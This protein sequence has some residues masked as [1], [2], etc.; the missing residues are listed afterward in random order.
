MPVYS[1]VLTAVICPYYKLNH[2]AN[3]FLCM[4]HSFPYFHIPT[5]DN[6]VP[7]FRIPSWNPTHLRLSSCSTSTIKSAQN[8]SRWNYSCRHP[9]ATP[10]SVCVCACVCMC[11]RVCVCVCDLHAL[12]SLYHSY[13]TSQILP[14]TVMFLSFFLSNILKTP[15]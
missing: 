11:V 10:T 15:T 13:G 8:S 3:H 7:L 1:P 6:T 2:T 12:T 14:C 9:Q 5:L 4:T